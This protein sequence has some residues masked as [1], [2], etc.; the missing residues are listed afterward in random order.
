LLRTAA[1]I[2]VKTFS[3]AKSRLDLPEKVK[4]SLCEMMLGE[5]LGTL[6]LSPLVEQTIVVTGDP[7]AVKIADGFKAVVIPD[8][9]EAGVNEAVS[10]AD[11][12]VKKSGI[13]ATVVLPQ[14]VPFTKTQ[15]VDFLLRI[16][17]PPS[18]VTIVPSRRFDGTNALVRMPPDIMGTSYDQD[19]YR[20]HTHIA[21]KHTRNS[22]V[23][24]VRRIMMD[25]DDMDDL[26]YALEQNEK[27]ELCE[28][29]R[30]LVNQGAP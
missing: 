7:T 1:I 24:F 23:L 9:E 13:G 2:P 25:I 26:K 28:R 21:K 19:S 5:L 10:L 12:Y 14:D 17:I 3:R 18:F 29:I 4:R 20:S 22:S 8:E 6:S 16:Q 15:D 11:D 30:A 27:P